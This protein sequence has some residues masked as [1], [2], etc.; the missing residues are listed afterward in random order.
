MMTT[1]NEQM[2]ALV[3]AWVVSRPMAWAIYPNAVQRPTSNPANKTPRDF[4]DD[5]ITSPRNILLVISKFCFD[6][7]DW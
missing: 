5:G 6:S 7:V 4:D 1:A 2:N 3:L